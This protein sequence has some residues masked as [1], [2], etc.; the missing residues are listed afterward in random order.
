[1]SVV[2]RIGKNV[3]NLLSFR[4]R[5][6]RRQAIVK[7]IFISSIH[8]EVEDSVS[9]GNIHTHVSGHSLDRNDF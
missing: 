7:G 3:M 1:M 5:L 6:Y 4:Q 2:D 8:I 9:S